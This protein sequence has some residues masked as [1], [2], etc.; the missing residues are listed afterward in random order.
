MVI[1]LTHYL[2]C[3]TLECGERGGEDKRG[4]VRDERRA[5]TEGSDEVSGGGVASV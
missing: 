4:E 1:A 2:T 3:M 5:R